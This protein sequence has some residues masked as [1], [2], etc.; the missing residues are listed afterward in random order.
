MNY[1]HDILKVEIENA[2]TS[3]LVLHSQ[4]NIYRDV[5]NPKYPN[6]MY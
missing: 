3:Q 5:Y 2:S 4:I 1:Y 6:C